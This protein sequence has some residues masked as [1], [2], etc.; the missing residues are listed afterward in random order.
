MCGTGR[1][2]AARRG[3][4]SN[5]ISPSTQATASP[6]DSRQHRDRAA[7]PMSSGPIFLRDSLFARPLVL[8]DP[9]FA[10]FVP[11]RAFPPAKHRRSVQVRFLESTWL[12]PSHATFAACRPMR[13]FADSINTGKRPP[14]AVFLFVQLGEAVHRL[15]R[16]STASG[17]CIHDHLVAQVHSVFPHKTPRAQTRFSSGDS[18]SRRV[19]FDDELPGRLPRNTSA[20]K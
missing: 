10:R 12:F 15:G 3:C 2:S 19:T 6:T 5:T 9:F 16:S 18:A 13:F 11:R 4:V 8:R 17:K 7:R 1:R 14:V 20:L